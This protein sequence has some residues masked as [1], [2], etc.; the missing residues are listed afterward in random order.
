MIDEFYNE[1]AYKLN[2]DKID[3]IA[4]AATSWYTNK[5]VRYYNIA[6]DSSC[7]LLAKVK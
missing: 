6:F 3:F 7:I 2:D 4:F 1:I 5:S